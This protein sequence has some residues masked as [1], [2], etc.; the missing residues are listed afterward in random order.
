MIA[1]NRVA[2]AVV[3]CATLAAGARH[4]HLD[5]KYMLNLDITGTGNESRITLDLEV[6][7]AG[8][9]GF[10]INK[11]AN[12]TGAD[13]FIGGVQG[14]NLNE[15]YGDDYHATTNG[16]PTRDVI[17]NW[18]VTSASEVNGTTKLSITRFLDTGDAEEDIKIENANIFVIWSIGANDNLEHHDIA[19]S[20]QLN[21]HTADDTNSSG[22]TAVSVSTLIMSLVAA[23]LRN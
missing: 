23:I 4:L 8:Y 7:T 11:F 10:G 3:F 5:D 12:M 21:L 22:V 14:A 6:T 9:V 17:Q 19:G 13:L 2:L 1:C 16:L 15:T 18:N 20:R